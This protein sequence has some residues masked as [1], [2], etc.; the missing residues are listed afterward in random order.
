MNVCIP[1]LALPSKRSL[2][3]AA[4]L[5]WVYGLGKMLAGKKD[6]ESFMVNTAAANEASLLQFCPG[7]FAKAVGVQ[8]MD[9]MLQCLSAC[10]V[11]IKK[12]IRRLV[13]SAQIVQMCI[14]SKSTLFFCHVCV[15]VFAV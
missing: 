13:S 3:K 9:D 6:T 1:A 8:V 2:A 11:L 5:V 4:A 12:R 15:C 7:I 10:L 14:L